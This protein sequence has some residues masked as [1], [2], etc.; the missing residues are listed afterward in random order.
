MKYQVEFV[1]GITNQTFK[2]GVYQSKKRIRSAKE[3]FDLEYGAYL[4]LRIKDE[5]G[6]QVQIWDV[7]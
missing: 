6:N 3:R 4:S 7:R 1:S 5:A 2:T